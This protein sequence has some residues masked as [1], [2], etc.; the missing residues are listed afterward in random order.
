MLKTA[1][2][3]I[4][5]FLG[6]VFQKPF[7][8][9]ASFVAV[10]CAVPVAWFEY[11]HNVAKAYVETEKAK[12]DAAFSIYTEVDHAYI[13]YIKTCLTLPRLDCYT[14]AR[15]DTV[16]PP[17]TEDEKVQQK[18]LFDMLTDVFESAFV[19]YVKYRDQNNEQVRKLFEGEWKTW[20]DYIV[21]FLER[22]AY[23]SV[24]LDVHGGYDDELNCFIQG[25][26]TRKT[27]PLDLSKVDKPLRARLDAWLNYEKQKKC[28][29]NP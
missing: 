23:L 9:V 17:L 15:S 8:E 28:P 16:T 5:Q 29:K 19:H 26:L 10:A 22:P 3:K 12:L 6:W 1:I 18:I 20:E 25:M 27:R 11:R 14:I 21:R 13:D 4:K 24:W 2:W 7:W